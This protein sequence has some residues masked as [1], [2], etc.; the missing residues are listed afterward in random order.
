MGMTQQT[1]VQIHPI[2]PAVPAGLLL[3]VVAGSAVAL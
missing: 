1:H 3:V 2:Y